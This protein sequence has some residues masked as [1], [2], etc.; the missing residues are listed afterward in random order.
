MPKKPEDYLANARE[1]AA[2]AVEH[3]EDQIVEQLVENDAASD[4]M[5]NDFPGGDSYHHENHVDKMYTLLEAAT[6]LDQL[7]NYEETDRG[8]WE[9][10]EPREAVKI[11]AAYT[12]GNAVYSMW[13]ELITEIN[14][15][16]E[17]EGPWKPQTGPKEWS[18]KKANAPAS[19]M[20]R[21]VKQIVKNWRR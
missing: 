18:P 13:R 8:L 10:Q 20:R 17:K 1:A 15:E 19:W 6:L 5:N 16:I 9:G 2:E 12:Y 11:Q 14:E 3:F 7:S 4:D 21:V